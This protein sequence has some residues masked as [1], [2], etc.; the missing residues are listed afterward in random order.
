MLFSVEFLGPIVLV[1]SAAALGLSIVMDVGR[2]GAERARQMSLK[3]AVE[4]KRAAAREWTARANRHRADLD[5]LRERYDASVVRRRRALGE[6]RSIEFGRI[7]M[8]HEIEGDQPAAGFWMLLTTSP[9]FA[10]VAREDVIFSRQI[11]DF[12]NVAHVWA[13]SADMAALLAG[14][15]FQPRSGVYPTQP[16]PLTAALQAGGGAAG[17]GTTG[18]GAGEA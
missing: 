8:V 2:L 5:A 14:G 10:D 11:W 12:R 16:V 7:E 4:K 18:G 1:A 15:A 17:G 9:D 13:E 3:L 6:I